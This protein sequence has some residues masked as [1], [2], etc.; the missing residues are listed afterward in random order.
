VNLLWVALGGAIGSVGRYLLGGVVHWFLPA[1]FPYG[2]VVVN[3]TGCLCFGIVAGLADYRFVVG[4]TTRLFVL[5]GVLGGF[6]TFSSYVFESFALV[7]DG[8]FLQAA[9]NAAGQVVAGFIALWVGYSVV[10]LH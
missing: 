6:T 10:G 4:P 3:I 1:T 7:R 8:E 9:I 5:I 2:T